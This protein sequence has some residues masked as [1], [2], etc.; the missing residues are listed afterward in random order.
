M[1]SCKKMLRCA[2]FFHVH[3]I[4]HLPWVERVE[5]SIDELEKRRDHKRT[6]IGV[7]GSVLD[8]ARREDRI[9]I[10]SKTVNFSW[11][12]GN[13]IGKCTRVH[14]IGDRTT[15]EIF[16]LLPQDKA[17]LARFTPR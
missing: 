16:V 1:C 13:K 7:I 5:K 3:T 15:L 9:H 8:K 10:R 12:R 11:Q 17:I 6:E 14:G 2:N 4:A